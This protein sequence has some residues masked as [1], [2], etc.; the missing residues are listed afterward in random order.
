MATP[1]PSPMSGPNRGYFDLA[2]VSNIQQNYLMDM[3]QSYP[4]VNNAATVASY[5]NNL[6]NKLQGLSQSYVQANTS[7]AAVLNQQNQMIGIINAEQERLNEKQYLMDQAKVQQD[8]IALLNNSYRLR[9]AQYTKMVIVLIIGLCIHIVLRLIGSYFTQVPSLFLVLLHIVNIVACLII[10]T[11]IYV[12]ILSRD[13]INFNQ[14]NLPPPTL[15]GVTVA[16]TPDSGSLWGDFGLGC[17][18]QDCCGPNTTW[19]STTGL[20][21]ANVASPSPSPSMTSGPATTGPAPSTP[22]SGPTTPGPA[23]TGPTTLIVTP[24]PAPSTALPTISPTQLTPVAVTARPT[25]LPRQLTPAPAP[26]LAAA[27]IQAPAPAQA[28]APTTMPPVP[29]YT[30]APAPAPAQ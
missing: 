3:T 8:R 22:T 23:T 15:S 18:G 12:D 16:S 30:I 5:V 20:C 25:I 27:P 21:D 19:N 7:G 14:L 29:T 24:A 26:A 9:Y 13:Q 4:N 17:A 2:G 10:I 11:Y 28:T 6:Q 1:A